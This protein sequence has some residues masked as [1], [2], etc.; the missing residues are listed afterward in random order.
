MEYRKGTRGTREPLYI[1]QNILNKSKMKLK[2]LAMSGFDYK[3]ANDIVPQIRIINYL[4]MYKLFNDVIK[5]IE[6]TMETIA[7]GS[8]SRR[9][10]LS[11]DENPTRDLPARSAIVISSCYR[12][13]APQPHIQGMHRRIQTY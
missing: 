13:D 2:N 5:F 10:M 9:K 1:D 3:N 11:W 8:D 12:N 7:I 6:E 4:K